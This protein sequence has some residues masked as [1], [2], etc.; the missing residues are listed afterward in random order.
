MLVALGAFS[1]DDGPPADSFDDDDGE[2]D[3]DVVDED[4]FVVPPPSPAVDVS[5]EPAPVPPESLA[6]FPPDS[7][8]DPDPEP[9]DDRLSVL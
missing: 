9:E 5:F 2:V 1:F 8:F 4:S 6:S 3:V 7:P